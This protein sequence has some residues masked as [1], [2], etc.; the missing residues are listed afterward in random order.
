MTHRSFQ[1]DMMDH[2]VCRR[3]HAQEKGPLFLY[4]KE[5]VVPTAGGEADKN[6]SRNGQV[7]PY[8]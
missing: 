5:R 1:G 7:S 8:L 6:R 3:A 4:E 2:K